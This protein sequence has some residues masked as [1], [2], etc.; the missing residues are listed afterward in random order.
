[1]YNGVKK[2]EDKVMEIAALLVAIITLFLALLIHSETR[3]N[4]RNL[5]AISRTLPSAHDIGRLRDDIERTGEYRGKVI[6]DPTKDTHIAYRKPFEKVPRPQ[7]VM[8]KIWGNVHKIAY[9]F[10]GNIDIPQARAKT[11]KWEIKS[12]RL[13]STEA[14]KWLMDGWEPF[15][16]TVDD[17]VWF[18]KAILE[19]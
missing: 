4:W 11:K 5:N 15:S 9:F 19:E 14:K 16:V 2:K 3:E 13:A 12:A 10:S 8:S 18:R 1:M 17:N 7:W 6:L